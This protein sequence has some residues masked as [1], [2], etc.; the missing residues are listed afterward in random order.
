MGRLENKHRGG[1]NNEKGARYEEFYAVYKIASSLADFAGQ[2]ILIKS[3]VGGA[4]VDDILMVNEEHYSYYQLKNVQSLLKYWGRIKDDFMAQIVLSQDKKEDFDITLV[5]SDSTF[6]TTISEELYPYTNF[7]Y[8]PYADSLY[9]LIAQ[10]PTLKDALKRLCVLEN[11]TAD[12]LYKIA[13]YL[14]G[15]WCAI[16]RQKGI[17]IADLAERIKDS[18]VNTILDSD[19]EI[20]A[21]C[22]SILDAIPDFSYRIRG[23]NIVWETTRSRN[24][25]TEWT[26]DLENKIIDMSPCSAKEI[27][28]IL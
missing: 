6:E 3:Q 25:S 16:D 18:S 8:F 9:E 26:R 15:E 28:K 1:L 10:S 17:T 7:E 24:N 13:R 21:D 20:S 19:R 27:F 14:I 23:K 12:A 11:A 2:Q 5:Y 4:Y 22:R